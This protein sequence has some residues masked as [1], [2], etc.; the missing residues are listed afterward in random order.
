MELAKKDFLAEIKQT[1]KDNPYIDIKYKIIFNCPIV[2]PYNRFKTKS[3]EIVTLKFFISTSGILGFTF[4]KRS[5][6]AV[7]QHFS[8]TDI[9]SIERVEEKLVDRLEKAR[10]MKNKIHSNLWKNLREMTVEEFEKEFPDSNLNPVYFIKRFPKY[11]QHTIEEG[12]KRAVESKATYF[13][14]HKTN[15]H[16]GRDLTI[17]FKMCEDGIYRGWFSS[18]YMG[19]GNG[20]YYLIL[21]ERVAIYCE[22]D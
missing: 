9:K 19:C 7:Y 1:V 18:E 20:D 16:S 14:S 11:R 5:G 2:L 12:I 10:K 21:N 8:N 17:E 6:Y 13:T 3:F 15:H 4:Y 22:R